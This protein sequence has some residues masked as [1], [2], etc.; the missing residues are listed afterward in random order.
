MI[1]LNIWK[2][3]K[4]FQTTSQIYN[5]YF[6]PMDSPCLVY[7]PLRK[8]ARPSSAQL[9]G[10]LHQ[11]PN[12][13][14]EGVPQGQLRRIRYR[15]G[16]AVWNTMKQDRFPSSLH[17]DF[18]RK[19]IIMLNNYYHEIGT[20]LQR[21]GHNWWVPW[22]KLVVRPAPNMGRS[23]PTFDGM[24]CGKWLVSLSLGELGSS[25]DIT[26]LSNGNDHPCGLLRN[27]Y[28]AMHNPNKGKDV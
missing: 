1:V 11:L 15:I 21:I 19:T 10:S 8:S 5:L 23:N 20:S 24:T 16:Q 6:F 14:C 17:W 13:W 7:F 12:S 9:R 18:I 22:M 2:N 25:E 4:M 26:Q 28:P 27:S 3:K